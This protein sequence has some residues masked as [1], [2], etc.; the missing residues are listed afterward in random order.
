[1]KKFILLPTFLF[2]TM[3]QNA[4]AY[5]DPG[6]I[7]AMFNLIIAGLVAGLFYIRSSI[8]SFFFNLKE[9]KNDIK[10]FYKF[11]KKTKSVVIY[12]ENYQYLKYYGKILEELSLKKK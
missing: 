12:C 11:Y 7:G 1:M 4:S 9:F 8:Y 10:N 2:A 6:G 3:T 5:I